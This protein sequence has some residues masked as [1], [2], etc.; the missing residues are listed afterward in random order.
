MESEPVARKPVE[1]APGR[2]EL[3]P[4]DISNYLDRADTNRAAG[5]YEDA[6][7]QYG[8]VIAC[9]SR[10]ERAQQ[11]LFRTRQAPAVSGRADAK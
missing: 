4:N 2:C 8:K 7:R 3:L 11:G 6:A 1:K 10:N 9:D 5:S